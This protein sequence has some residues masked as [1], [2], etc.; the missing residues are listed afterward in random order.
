MIEP[1]W[2]PF[3]P[4]R[5]AVELAAVAP[6][7]K[8]FFDVD[9]GIDYTMCARDEAHVLEIL[10]RADLDF[11]ETLAELGGP[12]ITEIPEHEVWRR[13]F[14]YDGPEGMRRVPLVS[15]ELGTYASSEF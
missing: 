3:E 8:R 5:E 4:S 9:F 15:M 2:R 6:E 12:V 14:W 13:T 7:A 11:E 1:S 10:R